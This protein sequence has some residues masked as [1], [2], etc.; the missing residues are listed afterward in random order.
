MKSIFVSLLLISSIYGMAQFNHPEGPQVKTQQ[1]ILS[2]TYDAGISSFKGVPFAQPPIGDLR[3]QAPQAPKPWEGVRKADAFGPRAM[4]RAI[5][6]DMNFRSDGMSEDCLYLNIWTPAKTGKEGLPV[7]VYFYGGGLFTGDGSEYRY[8]GE[9]MA[10]RGIISITVNYRLN[11]FGYMSHAGLSAESPHKASG[12]YG[13]MDQWAALTWIQENITAFGGDPKRVTIAGESAGSV[14]VTAQM[15]SPLSKHLIAGAIGSSGSIMG[16]LGAIPLEEGEKA[17]KE[18]EKILGVT[19]IQEMRE[20]SAEDILKATE[21]M[22]LTAFRPTI[23][24]YFFPKAV[25]AIFKAGE[26][27]HIPLLL[28]WNSQEGSYQGVLQGKEP[29][30]ANFQEAL[31]KMFPGRGALAFAAY[32]ANTEEEVKQAA[33]DLAGDNFTGFSTWKWGNMHAAHGQP[34]FQYY[35]ARPRPALDENSPKG[36]THSAEIEYAMGNLPTNTVYD[37]SDDDYQVSTI[38][39]SYYLNF[40]KTGN[41]NGLGLPQ[42][43]T[44]NE[45][46]MPHILHL[47]V[48]TY[49]K[50]DKLRARYEFLDGVYYGK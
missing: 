3:W 33:G 32:H 14:S 40:V 6:S 48:D 1:G 4:Q 46:E 23:D 17:G 30:V 50:P 31:E 37:W 41:P 49:A 42:W 9:S 45:G 11:V 20:I 38:F 22:G 19:S 34:V 25:D 36:A 43:P 39:Q 35:Y 47:D 13:F 5:F 8:D 18:F 10:R 12:N 7:L 44:V 29:T 28:G 27:A 24:G 2:G 16:T 15:A 26:Q 21:K